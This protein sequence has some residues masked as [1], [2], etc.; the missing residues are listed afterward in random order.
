LVIEHIGTR[1][2]GRKP[3]PVSTL[4]RPNPP[5][6]AQANVGHA[7]AY[8]ADA[9]TAGAEEAFRSHFGPAARAYPVFNGTGANVA[10]VEA[11]CRPHGAVICTDVAHLFIDEC[12]APE[13]IAGVKLLPVSTAHG[14]LSPADITRWE[15]RRGD[16]HFAQPRLV[17][18][19]QSTELG[20]VYTADET[21]AIADAAHRHG[22]QLHLDGARLANAAAALD[23][24]L[25]ALTTD[26]GVDAISFGATKNGVLFGD[27][28]VF[29]RPELA[30]GFEFTRMQLGQLASKTRFLAAQLTALL[31]DGLWLRNALH[32]N[33]MA[34]RLA[35]L[36]E[37][38]DGVELVHPVEANAVFV[39]LER[40]AID[41]LLSAWPAEQPFYVWDEATGVCR[42]MCSWDTEPGD[43]DAFGAAVASAISG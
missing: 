19:T 35:D 37:P 13:R 1:V 32:A 10:A 18:I 5:V 15:A 21:R 16:E 26:V 24:P 28:V 36:V 4:A 11:L 25:R 29:C 42:W 6:L 17:S 3:T 33:R 27:A 31:S 8:G 23:L 7:P 43:V 39:R 34:R 9:W 38:L 22:M 12:G 14:K 40:A 30:E 41:R 20:T 2:S